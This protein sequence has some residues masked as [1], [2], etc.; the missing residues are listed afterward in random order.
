MLLGGSP[1]YS[2]ALTFYASSLE[3]CLLERPS[4]DIGHLFLERSPQAGDG[5]WPRTCQSTGLVNSSHALLIYMAV[6]FFEDL[7]TQA[8]ALTLK[9]YQL[10]ANAKEMP[11]F[12]LA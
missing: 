2:N 10:Q 11:R 5:H 8:V 4:V 9:Q 3:H 7:E 12:P 1:Y 6:V